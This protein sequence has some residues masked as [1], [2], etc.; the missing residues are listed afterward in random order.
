MDSR[1]RDMPKTPSVLL[2]EEM[3]KKGLDLLDIYHHR[4]GDIIRFKNRLTGKVYLYI[5]KKHVR[6]LVD[7]GELKKLIEELV[8]TASQ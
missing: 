2:K 8:K 3:F 5:S 6:D 7:V 4:D 1:V